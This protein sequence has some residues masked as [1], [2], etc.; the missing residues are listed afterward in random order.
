MHS[1]HA[2]PGPQCGLPR[3]VTQC[4]S[5]V[6]PPHWF[7]SAHAGAAGDLQSTSPAHGTQVLALPQAGKFGSAQ[8]LFFTHWTQ[9]PAVVSHTGGSAPPHSAWALQALTHSFPTQ[10]KPESQSGLTR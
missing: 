3:L 8:S 10:T 1:T 5:V 7:Q 2:F 9:W 4:A 6:Q